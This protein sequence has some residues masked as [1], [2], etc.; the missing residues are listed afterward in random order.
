MT[1]YEVISKDYISNCLIE[2]IKAKMRNPQVKIYFCRPRITENGNF[3]SLHFMWEDENGSYDFYEPEAAGLPPWKQ[4]LFK[5][6][7]R[8][9][10]KGFAEKYAAYRNGIKL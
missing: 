3:Q 4:F 1:R 6:H 5:G 8:K 10:K 9:F 7:I 2:V